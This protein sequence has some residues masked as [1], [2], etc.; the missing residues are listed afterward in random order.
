VSVC[1]E[2]TVVGLA[3]AWVT[4]G[5]VLW[6]KVRGVAMQSIGER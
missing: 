2:V 5:V 3:T 1:L 6:G 4:G